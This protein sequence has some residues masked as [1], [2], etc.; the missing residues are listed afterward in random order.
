MS[1][2]PRGEK[3]ATMARR[4]GEERRGE[5]RR[6]EERRG[7]E[8]RGEE[9]RGE[10]RRGEERRGEERRGEE[11]RGEERDERR[12]GQKTPPSAAFFRMY[13]EEDAE[14]GLRPPCLGEPGAAAQ[15]PAR[16]RADR[17][18]HVRPCADP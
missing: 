18:S 15:D 13:D 8:R 9:R 14:R 1:G 5:E 17:G 12:H 4:R 7:E 3:T 6:G 16:H 11:R 10:E 2:A